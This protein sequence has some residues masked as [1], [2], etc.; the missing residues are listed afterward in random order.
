M[1]LL[2]IIVQILE[3]VRDMGIFS[4]GRSLVYEIKPG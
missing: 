3:S 1:A 2:L 4:D